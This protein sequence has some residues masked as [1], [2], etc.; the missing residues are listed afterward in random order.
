MVQHPHGDKSVSQNGISLR[1]PSLIMAP[2][3][4]YENHILLHEGNLPFIKVEKSE[5]DQLRQGNEVVIAESK[6]GVCPVF[7]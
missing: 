1:S 7:Y 3:F 5:T 4:T 6:G 2:V